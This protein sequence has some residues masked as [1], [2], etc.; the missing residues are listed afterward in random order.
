[1]GSCSSRSQA[2]EGQR[3]LSEREG[4][5]VVKALRVAACLASSATLISAGWTQTAPEP[6]RPVICLELV[7]FLRERGG[8]APGATATITVEEAQRYAAE[9]NDFPCRHAVSEMYTV[10]VRVR[11]RLLEAI[12]VSPDAPAAASGR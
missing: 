12:G 11:P 4:G 7:K 10:G 1:M 3:G 8:S 6:G 5:I 2:G 9:G